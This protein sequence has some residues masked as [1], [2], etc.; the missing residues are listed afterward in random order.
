MYFIFYWKK[1]FLVSLN[2]TIISHS[3]RKDE[4]LPTGGNLVENISHIPI[5]F[6]R[7]NDYKWRY[8]HL[9]LVSNF[10]D[11]EGGIT[12][13]IMTWEVF[14]ALL[15]IVF[16]V[17]FI[18]YILNKRINPTKSSIHPATEYLDG[19]RC[20]V[21]RDFYNYNHIYITTDCVKKK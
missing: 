21:C 18:S 8:L 3:T 14:Q 12:Q 13:L 19:L 16:F 4:E 10:C 17:S 2:V 11:H 20:Q 15:R 7:E 6:Q 1:I 5:I 9:F